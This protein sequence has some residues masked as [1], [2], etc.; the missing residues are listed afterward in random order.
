MLEKVG[1]IIK[2]DLV[3]LNG[4]QCTSCACRERERGST[5]KL[6]SDAISHRHGESDIRHYVA[7]LAR[8]NAG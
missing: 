1:R 6:A 5:P 3:I 4:I 2:R 8:S 7:D